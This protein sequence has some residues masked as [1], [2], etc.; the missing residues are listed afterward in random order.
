VAIEALLD[1]VEA[2]IDFPESGDLRRDLGSLLANVAELL[3]A[4]ETGPPLTALL[5]DTQ[6]DHALREVWQQQVF[7]PVRGRYLERVAAAREA[8][9][10]PADVADDEILDCAFGPLWFRALT[11]PEEINEAFGQTVARIVFD[12]LT[13]VR[14][15]SAPRA[16]GELPASFENQAR[17]HVG[18]GGR[19][20]PRISRVGLGDRCC[21]RQ[22]CSRSAASGAG[23]GSPGASRAG[24]ALDALLG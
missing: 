22:G 20:A 7:R 21:S 16:S 12:G 6:H 5:A 17:A 8:G 2:A 9:Q 15:H 14:S 4:P 18:D 1:E 19:A 11:R 10:L 24:E 23:P 3:G 13:H